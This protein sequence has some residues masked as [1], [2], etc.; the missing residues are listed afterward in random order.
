VDKIR[1]ET[2]EL[3]IRLVK[4]ALTA[5][6]G[7]YAKAAKSLGRTPSGLYYLARKHG[8]LTWVAGLKY[9]AAMARAKNSDTMDF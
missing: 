3:E 4:E 7:N 8:L 6:D 2:L 1:Q 9:R 5:A